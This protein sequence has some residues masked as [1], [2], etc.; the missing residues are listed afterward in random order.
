MKCQI[1]PAFSSQF[2]QLNGEVWMA[3]E[4]GKGSLIRLSIDS[5]QLRARVLEFV[6]LE[7]DEVWRQSPI[8]AIYSAVNEPPGYRQ[9]TSRLL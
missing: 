6:C 2:S 1:R 9:T 5:S 8:T 3:Q 4:T 7:E